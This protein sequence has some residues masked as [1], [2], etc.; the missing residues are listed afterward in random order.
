MTDPLRATITVEWS[1]SASIGERSA[2]EH[3]L[4]HHREQLRQRLA[5]LEVVQPAVTLSLPGEH[6]Y[7]STACLHGRHDDCRQQCK[8][9]PSRCAC[10]G[11]D[12]Q[13]PA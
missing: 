10:T 3:L 6:H 11:C 13:E 5:L 4:A 1:P 9:C 8:W 7:I 12:H 2:V